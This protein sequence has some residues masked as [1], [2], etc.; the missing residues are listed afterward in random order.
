MKILCVGN[1]NYDILFPLDRMPE[2]HEKM[3]CEH[4]VHGFGGSAAN[5]AY[6]LGRLGCDVRMAG[7]V[8]HDLP[9]QSHLDHLAS[10]GVDVSGIGKVPG[11]SSGLV[12]IFASAREKR[13]V[14]TPGANMRARF[15]E[16]DLNGCGLVFLSGQDL[17]LLREYVGAAKKM[18]LNVLCGSGGSRDAGLL[19][20]VT[21]MIVNRDEM[22]AVT[23]VEDPVEGIRALD[24]K[25]S[26]VTLPEGGCV[27]SSGIH[28]QEI[29]ADEIEPV[30][31]TGAGDAFAA[32]YLAGVAADQTPEVCG[33]WG[34]MMAREVLM[35]WG[36]RP[37]I[38]IP[39]L[40][41]VSH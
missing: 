23:G 40:I 35:G 34:N 7:A 30:D 14:R 20:R 37:E 39:E 3:V 24:M 17:N 10:A 1:I 41:K 36:A 19:E 18:G 38:T 31:R 9:G 13:M 15:R 32:G 8:G 33:Q 28:V 4:A 29:P 16:E 25:I 6:W 11:V 5:T 2:H 12:V 27:V 21:G 22:K 26:A